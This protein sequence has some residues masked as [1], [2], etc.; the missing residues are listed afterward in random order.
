ME[1]TT[2]YLPADLRGWLREES[3][4]TGRT[5]AE[6]MREAL[7][8]YAARRPRPLPTSIGLGS[9]PE[10]S[11]ADVEDWLRDNWRPV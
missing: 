5:Q 8:A 9:D 10:L 1:K 11:G 4:R 7:E 3:R 6:L 2:V